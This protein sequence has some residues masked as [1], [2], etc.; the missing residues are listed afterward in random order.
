MKTK[1]VFQTDHSGV[2][3]GT[4]LADESPLEPGVFHIPGG[5]VEI[6]PPKHSSLELARWLDGSWVIEQIPAPQE[7]QKRPATHKEVE[8]DRLLEYADP[9]TGSDRL[10]SESMRMQIMGEPGFE[11]VR[12]RAIARFEEIQAQYPWPAK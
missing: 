9:L 6:K 8:A 1:T 11:E 2:F 10:F 3:V 7:E 12:T 5:C 4:T